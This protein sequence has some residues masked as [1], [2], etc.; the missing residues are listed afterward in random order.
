[1]GC[2]YGNPRE[3]LVA[4]RSE[5]ARFPCGNISRWNG[6]M[7]LQMVVPSRTAVLESVRRMCHPAA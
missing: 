3:Q 7:M 5:L 1:M 6:W 2:N 4:Y